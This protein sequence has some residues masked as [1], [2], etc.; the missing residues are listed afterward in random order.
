MNKLKWALVAALMLTTAG[1]AVAQSP[2]V[3][4]DVFSATLRGGFAGN[5]TPTARFADLARGG[6]VT[7]DKLAGKLDRLRTA[8]KVTDARPA[9]GI[10]P[11]A[12]PLADVAALLEAFDRQATPAVFVAC[13]NLLTL[14]GTGRTSGF[15]IYAA[16]ANGPVAVVAIADG[17]PLAAPVLAPS[18]NA[19]QLAET[20]RRL[21]PSVPAA[22]QRALLEN[23]I[24]VGSGL[25]MVGARNAPLEAALGQALGSGL[26][27]GTKPKVVAPPGTGDEAWI[28]GSILASLPNFNQLAVARAAYAAD[29]AGTARRF[30]WR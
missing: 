7:A 8:L 24:V 5:P 4:V 17:V 2:P 11:C 12:A 3:V 9:L 27:D 16:D 25:S 20:I 18:S 15:S 29:P 13:E 23:V 19:G 14:F 30:G 6:P 1:P 26:P 21:L 22:K 28:G 10:A